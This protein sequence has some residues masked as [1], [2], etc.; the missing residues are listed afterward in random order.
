MAPLFI[1]QLYLSNSSL[2]RSDCY[3]DH[4]RFILYRAYKQNRDS[5][6]ADEGFKPEQSLFIVNVPYDYDLAN[7]VEI[8]GTFGSVEKCIFV[9]ANVSG[10]KGN[11]YIIVD[12]NLLLIILNIVHKLHF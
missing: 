11:Y 2:F 8:F 9:D 10:F 4:P 1:S 6:F 5:V 3:H 12:I 7:L